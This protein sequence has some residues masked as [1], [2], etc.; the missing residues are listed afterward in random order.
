MIT[1]SP[2][3][4]E[5]QGFPFGAAFTGGSPTVATKIQTHAMVSDGQRMCVF[6]FAQSDNNV[7]K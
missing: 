6:E 4:L 5:P 7:L 3:P 1:F 2:G